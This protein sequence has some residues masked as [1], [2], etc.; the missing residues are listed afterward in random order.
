MATAL[1]VLNNA[2]RLAKVKGRAQA[3]SGADK[4]EY[5]SIL[6]DM[7]ESWKSEGCDLGLG[8]L[9]QGDTVYI[10]DADLL[11]IRYNLAEMIAENVGKDI[12]I[13]LVQRARDLKVTLKSKYFIQQTLEQPE[14]FLNTNTTNIEAG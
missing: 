5:L 4:T 1:D 3:L 6:N 12:S 13:N 2:A 9:V 10:D 8:T 11:C 7:L 14:I